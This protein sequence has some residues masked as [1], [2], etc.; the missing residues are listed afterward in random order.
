MVVLK[1]VLVSV[2]ASVLLGQPFNNKEGLVRD[3]ICLFIQSRE[4]LDE[5]ELISYCSYSEGDNEVIQI[6]LIPRQVLSHVPASSVST[7]LNENNERGSLEGDEGIILDESW[8]YKDDFTSWKVVFTQ[9]L[10]NPYLTRKNDTGNSDIA[11]I[12]AL[13]RRHGMGQIGEDWVDSYVF[14]EVD[15][16]PVLENGN[17]SEILSQLIDRVFKDVNP[18]HFLRI[19]SWM[20]CVATIIVNQEGDAIFDSLSKET[21]DTLLDEKA[22]IVAQEYCKN[23]FVP[24]KIRGKNVTCR[25]GIPIQFINK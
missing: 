10:F 17:D 1:T 19:I 5:N 11:D 25:V 9:S 23:H 4:V 2:I 7:E 14:S 18:S 8:S 15:E 20:P 12:E 13:M 6:E 3:L 24:A 16:L 22:R 21:G